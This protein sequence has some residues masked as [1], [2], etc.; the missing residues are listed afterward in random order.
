MTDR[1][2]SL[3]DSIDKIVRALKVVEPSVPT[4]H[5]ELKLAPSDIQALKFISANPGCMSSALAQ[6]L[7][8]APTTATSIADRLVTRGFVDRQRSEENRRIV[9]LSLTS[10]GDHA[11]GRLVA[12]ELAKCRFMLSLMDEDEQKILVKL[13]ARIAD[14][15]KDRPMP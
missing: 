4:A 12:E 6:S 2:Q 5:G 9:S 13:M 14:N 8:V 3:Q 15:I 7:D 10:D 11:L 1:V